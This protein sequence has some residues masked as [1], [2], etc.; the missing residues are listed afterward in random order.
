MNYNAKLDRFMSNVDEIIKLIPAEKV[1]MGIGVFNQN[2]FEVE[3]KIYK[4]KSRGLQNFIFF[5]YNEI[6]SER[7]YMGAIQRAME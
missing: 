2:H 4:A 6:V 5:S 7:A 1:I 3:S